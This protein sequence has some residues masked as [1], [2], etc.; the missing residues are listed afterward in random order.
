M[1]E[2]ITETDLIHA[3]SGVF[4]T[5]GYEGASMALISQATGL[6][7]SSLYHR[8]PDGKQQMARAV[9]HAISGGIEK[10]ALAPLNG[11]GS[12]KARV[13]QAAQRLNTFYENGNKPCALDTLSI[14]GDQGEAT[15]A[16]LRESYDALI[17]GFT[18]IAIEAGTKPKAAQQR[19]IRAIVLI[20]GAL[21]VT[22]ITGDSD[23][24]KRVIKELPDLLCD[25]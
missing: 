25:A 9:A 8:F 13:K 18:N 6:K 23:S 3:L 10:Q 21:V 20:E 7:K 2:K 11:P 24:F 4:R 16:E 17:K 22:R 14:A 19:A 5:Y 1:P 15:L 12:P